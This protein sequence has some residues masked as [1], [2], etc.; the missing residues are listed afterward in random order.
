ANF[1]DDHIGVVVHDRDVGPGIA[2]DLGREYRAGINPPANEV[3]SPSDVYETI[4]GGFVKAMKS[5]GG[6]TT[7]L[8]WYTNQLDAGKVMVIVDAG[9]RTDDAMR[10][11][12]DHGGMSSPTTGM[13]ME[14]T[15]ATTPTPTPTP[16][17]TTTP[18]EHMTPGREEVHM[19]VMEEE[20]VVE[21][22]P[23][24]VGEVRVASE[25]TSETVDIPTS[26]THEEIRVERRRLDHPM[27]PDE[28]KGAT[29]EK[30]VIRMPIVE[31]EIRVT[32]TPIIREELVITRMPVTER[33]T[34]HETVMHAEPEVETTG[35]VHVEDRTHEGPAG[36]ERP[37]A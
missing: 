32:K 23:H 17:P 19:P 31:E 30:G 21:R 27:H 16:T 6:P 9:N 13:P 8:G 37:A 28:Y 33:Q 12:H 1:S 3:T 29:T 24:Q 25:T 18:T 34:L 2:D 35:D 26:V 5:G 36:E 22:M 7:D 11:M 14:R 10:I 4:P 20:V 15:A